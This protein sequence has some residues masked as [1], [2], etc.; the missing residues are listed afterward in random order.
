MIITL[1]SASPRRKELIK[2][3]PII[4]S[5]NIKVS[6]INEESVECCTPCELVQ[7]LATAKAE[8]VFS[9]VGGIVIGADTVVS[10][11][12]SIFG[13]PKTEQEARDFFSELCGKTHEVITGI[14]II[15]KKEKIVAHEKTFVTFGKYDNRLIEQYI[16]SGSPFDKA[17]GY[18]IQD[19]MLAPLVERIDGDLDNVIGLPTQLLSKILED[20]LEKW[21]KI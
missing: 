19:E 2:K 12:N 4:T 18:G 17:G 3:I 8:D 13:K 15:T 21:Q 20:N 6:N 1:A 11:G 16:K 7:K 9:S 10:L 5:V 14:A